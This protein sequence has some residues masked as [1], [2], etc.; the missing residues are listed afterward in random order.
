MDNG[1][2]L[3]NLH[4][5]QHLSEPKDRARQTPSDRDCRPA[6]VSAIYDAAQQHIEL[7]TKDKDFG[8]QCCPRPE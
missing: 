4:R 6:P 3:E 1:F 8:L 2:W 5:I 7:V